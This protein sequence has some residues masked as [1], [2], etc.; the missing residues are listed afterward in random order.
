MKELLKMKKLIGFG[1][2]IIKVPSLNYYLPSL[3]SL[4]FILDND[5]NKNNKYFINMKP[6]I[7]FFDG[8]FENLKIIK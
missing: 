7:K 1:A 2:G 4:K 5:K 6:R 8:K 3:N